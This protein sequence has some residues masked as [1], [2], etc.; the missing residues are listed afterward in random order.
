MDAR[1]SQGIILNTI[2]HV[3]YVDIWLLLYLIQAKNSEYR[4]MDTSTNAAPQQQKNS[5]DFE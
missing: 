5:E 3:I 2:S 4:N 1:I